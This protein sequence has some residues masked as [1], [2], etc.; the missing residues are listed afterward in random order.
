MNDTK[1]ISGGE[2][3]VW[4]GGDWV[5][6]RGVRSDLSTIVS[7]NRH[8]YEV[9]AICVSPNG[10]RVISGSPDGTLMVWDTATG[11]QV[12]S[13]IEGHGG[14]LSDV[15]VTPDGQRFVYLSKDGT[16]RVW[17][18]ERHEQ[19]AVL[20]GHSDDV[21]CVDISLDVKTAITGSDDKTVL[22]W[23][24]DA[25]DGS[26]KVLEGHSGAVIT[27]K[28]VTRSSV[29]ISHKMGNM[30]FHFHGMMQF[31]GIWKR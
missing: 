28:V 6:I 11:L 19:L 16:V 5:H 21:N 4:R 9:S 15:A 22:M 30:S 12:G 31:C 2:K 1:I 14:W 25:C 13:T 18:L 27:P 3:V 29:C 10:T 20:E 8:E 26:H 17:D 7:S 24:L 23:D